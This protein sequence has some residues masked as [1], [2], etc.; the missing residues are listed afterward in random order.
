MHAG[1]IPR[2][3]SSL[4]TSDDRF[5]FSHTFKLAKPD[6]EVFQRALGTS[7]RGAADV[8]DDLIENVLATSLG[9][10]AVS[11]RRHRDADQGVGDAGLKEFRAGEARAT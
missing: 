8:V 11:V 2:R 10:T 1:L 3:F 7:A 4:F 9:M 5:I 6:P